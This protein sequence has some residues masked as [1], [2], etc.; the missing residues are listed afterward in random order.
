M[1]YP[2][3]NVIPAKA[4]IHAMEQGDKHSASELTWAP[5]Y[6]GATEVYS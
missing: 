3:F 4:G 6:A 1:T 5:A 2:T